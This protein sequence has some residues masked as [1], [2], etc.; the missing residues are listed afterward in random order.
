[1]PRILL[2]ALFFLAL[3]GCATY[4]DEA[5]SDEP[6]ALLVFEKLE[7]GFASA[8]GATQVVPLEL[9]G[10]PPN[11]WNKW[12]YQRFRVYPGSMLLFVQAEV[13][14]T[15]A[16]FGY[17]DFEAREGETYTVSRTVRER[18]ILIVVLDS[19]ERKVNSAVVD[20]VPIQAPVTVPI[21]IP[22]Y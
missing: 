8:F 16:G 3:S 20:K 18:D 19:N 17:L 12:D 1:M 9:N 22:T 6:H 11:E 4:Y 10:L 21:Y 15:I 5:S 7:S 14:N 13:S 2:A